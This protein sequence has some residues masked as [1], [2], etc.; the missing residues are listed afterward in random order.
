MN[1]SVPSALFVLNTR[2]HTQNKERL[3]LI[4][5]ELWIKL[6]GSPLLSC[7]TMKWVVWDK[8]LFLQN[9]TDVMFIYKTCVSSTSLVRR[10]H[11]P[12][13]H[14]TFSLS[15]INPS[16]ESFLWMELVCWLDK[17]ACCLGSD[18][19]IAKGWN[20]QNPKFKK[21]VSEIELEL[22]CMISLAGVTIERAHMAWWWWWYRK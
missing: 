13:T 10:K 16:V 15:S 9:G 2:T 5:E 14:C 4:G 7:W 22:V 17:Q 19:F 11:Q 20:R 18:L 21:I 8:T 1:Y 6:G 12:S 3:W